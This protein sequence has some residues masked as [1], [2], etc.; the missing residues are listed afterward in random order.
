MTA[1]ARVEFCMVPV[2]LIA[3]GCLCTA[4]FYGNFWLLWLLL[5]LVCACAIAFCTL[6]PKYLGTQVDLSPY[7]IPVSLPDYESVCAALSA[8]PVAEDA[9]VCFRKDH[10]ITLRLLVQYCPQFDPEAISA[11]RKA[12]NRSINRHC[13]ISQVGPMPDVL[14]R[15][16]INLVV[17]DQYADSANLWLRRDPVRLLMR[18]EAILNCVICLEKKILYIPA[19]LYPLNW[20]EIR[21]YRYAVERLIDSFR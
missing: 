3:L 4:L 5:F 1:C 17:M 12:L 20:N 10:G 11:R 19:C 16:R 14:Q 8:A 9:A 18:N 6:Y 21:R 2:A 15:M 7:E 13:G